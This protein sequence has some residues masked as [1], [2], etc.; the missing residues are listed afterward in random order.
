MITQ[1]LA[2]YPSSHPILNIHITNYVKFLVTSAGEHFSKWRQIITFLLTM[3]Q[4]LDHITAGAAPAV[5][6]DL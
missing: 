2:P 1:P 6:D 5:P 4:A 3:Y